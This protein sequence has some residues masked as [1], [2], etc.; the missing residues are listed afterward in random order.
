MCSHER[1]NKNITIQSKST[2][3][4]F[5]TN[6][7][8]LTFLLQ[9]SYSILNR[10]GFHKAIY[11]LRLKFVLWAHLFSLIQHH[12]FAPYAQLIVFSPRFECALCFTPCAQL[13]K[14]PP[15]IAHKGF[16]YIKLAIKMEQYFKELVFQGQIDIAI[17]DNWFER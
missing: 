15:Q 13:L 11:A 17:S 12:V 4:H 16:S 1:L 6:L 7:L 9:L 3:Y 14:N 2:S 10:G 8:P 5:Q